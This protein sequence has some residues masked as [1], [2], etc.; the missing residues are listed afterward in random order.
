[1]GGLKGGL[2]KR[3]EFLLIRQ[4]YQKIVKLKPEKTKQ[5]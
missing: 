5:N 2:F 4:I 1:M 3:N